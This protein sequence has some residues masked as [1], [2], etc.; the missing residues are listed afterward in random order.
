MSGAFALRII[1]R[2][3]LG[4]ENVSAGIGADSVAGVL[5]DL[6]RNLLGT[7]SH[8]GQLLLSLTSMVRAGRRM[9]DIAI[10]DVIQMLRLVLLSDKGMTE[11][12]LALPNGVSEEFLISLLLWDRRSG[13]YVAPA[14]ADTSNSFMDTPPN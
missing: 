9:A 3:F 1:K 6:G 7:L 14:A 11:V 12:F 10:L 5:D 8:P 13:T 4:D 2:C